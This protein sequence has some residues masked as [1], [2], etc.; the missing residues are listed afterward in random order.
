VKDASARIRELQRAITSLRGV[1]GARV[2]LDASGIGH[3]RVLVVPERDVA[4][5]VRDIRDVAL[6]RLRVDIAPERIEV[7]VPGRAAP[8]AL[9]PPRR[10]LASLTVERTNGRFTARVALDLEGDRLVGASQAPSL[11]KFECRSV[12]GAVLH[13]VQELVD[14]PLLLDEVT[15]VA[16]G[17]A[18]LAV[19]TLL[20]ATNTLVGAALIR[21]DEHDAIAR[22]TLH[23][24]N[25]ALR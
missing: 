15:L 1:R 16:M 21:T 7:V 11:H 2:Q 18:R 8:A 13:G 14:G 22:A 3:V 23:A 10:R 17:D 20:L 6:Q 19:V 12:A 9:E 5:T 24:L 4:Q 25:R